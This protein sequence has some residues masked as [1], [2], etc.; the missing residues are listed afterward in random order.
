MSV[1]QPHQGVKENQPASERCQPIP[2]V[3]VLF[4]MN[5][6]VAQNISELIAVKLRNQIRG[7]EHVTPQPVTGG[8]GA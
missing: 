8:G 1:G 5:E 7:Q 4:H 6:F 3:I 2:Q